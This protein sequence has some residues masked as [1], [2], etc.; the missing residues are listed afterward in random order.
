MKAELNL[1][2]AEWVAVINAV[3]DNATDQ[4]YHYDKRQRASA[5]RALRKID[6]ALGKL[7]GPIQR[8]VKNETCLGT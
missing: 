2:V 4:C 6:R 7:G 5:A 3:H 8:W 1:S